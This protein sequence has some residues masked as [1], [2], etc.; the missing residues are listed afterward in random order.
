M[1]NAQ[2]T[3]R[4]GMLALSEAQRLHEIESNPLDA[5]QVA[6]FQMFEQNNWSDNQRLAYIRS[7]Y[8]LSEPQAAE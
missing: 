2:K 3:H 6:M 1:E 4:Q 5:D 7:R 8:G